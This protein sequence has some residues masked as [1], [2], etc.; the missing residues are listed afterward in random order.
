MKSGSNY[1]AVTIGIDAIARCHSCIFTD[2]LL[3][4]RL[5]CTSQKRVEDA[6]SRVSLRSPINDARSNR[7]AMTR[8][9]SRAIANDRSNF[10]SRSSENP[11]PPARP[12]NA[13]FHREKNS[14]PSAD[15]P[16]R[17]TTRKEIVHSTRL[18]RCEYLC[19]ITRLRRFRSENWAKMVAREKV[20]SLR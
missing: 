19:C 14:F 1:R 2:S 5:V 20:I 8:Q 17:A 12:R 16:L 13:A 10:H 9:R 7:S 4:P 18:R 11:R 6:L 15:M 3:N